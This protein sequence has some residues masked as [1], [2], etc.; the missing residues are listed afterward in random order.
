MNLVLAKLKHGFHDPI[1]VA[2]SCVSANSNKKFL[3]L[4]ITIGDAT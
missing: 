4:T 1:K 3:K 2:A